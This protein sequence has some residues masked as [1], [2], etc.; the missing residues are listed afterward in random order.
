MA[1]E[2]VQA[3]IEKYDARTGEASV[4]TRDGKVLTFNVGTVQMRG[5]T[6]KDIV[7]GK[8]ITVRHAF[9]GGVLMVAA[10]D[11]LRK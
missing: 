4:K 10:P 8:K 2:E 3:L 7:S 1:E 9:R 11:S 6:A 5:L